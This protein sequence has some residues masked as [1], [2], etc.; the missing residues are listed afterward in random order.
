MK[1]N[2]K[3]AI[4][5]AAIS[6]FNTK[7]FHATSIRDISTKANVNVANIAYYFENKHG[8]LEYCLTSFFEQY[9]T[10]IEAAMDI[11]EEDPIACLKKV[12]KNILSFQC[13]NI[14]FTRFILREMSID[15][16]VVREIMSTYYVKE[17]Y[18]LKKILEKGM[19]K[20]VMK[21]HSM[22]Y[23]MIQFK[24]MLTMPFLNT[25]YVT[26]VLHV[27]PH[28]RFFEEKYLQEIYQWIDGV[29]GLNA[30]ITEKKAV[31]R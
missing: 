2:S 22:A 17:K 9:L 30:F 26:E 7:G 12:S 25:Q 28:E 14:H 23:L 18:F 19:Q 21:P 11:L 4:I 5:Q 3:E 24:G 10:E 20:K 27:F 15:S 8:L 29:L 1:K 6:L 31:N 13:N 16:Q